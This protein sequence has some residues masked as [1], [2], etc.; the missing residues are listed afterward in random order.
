MSQ[1]LDGLLNAICHRGGEHADVLPLCLRCSSVYAGALFGGIF[2]FIMWLARRPRIGMWAIVLNGL[3]FPVMGLVGFAGVYGLVAAG[4]AVKV[5]SALWFG[6]ALAFFSL[7]AI[8][9]MTSAKAR[10]GR[11]VLPRLGLLAGFGAV[12]A[13]VALD[14][15]VALRAVGIAALPG[16]ALVFV[17]VNGA[18]A[19]GLLRGVQRPAVRYV[20]VSG[21]TVCFIAAEFALFA[22]WRKL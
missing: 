20:A 5:F 15:A 19:L 10:T 7:N 3:A 22:L 8:L 9:A 4:E 16:L 14:S 11:S 18:F 21:L 12:T 17:L 6:S 13:L 1:F 2:E